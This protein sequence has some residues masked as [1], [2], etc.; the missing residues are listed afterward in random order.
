MA[1]L[2]RVISSSELL[3]QHFQNVWHFTS[4]DGVL[5]ETGVKDAVIPGMVTRLRNHQNANLIYST[6]SVQQLLPTLQPASVFSMAGAHG[7]LDGQM[8]HPSV[9]VLFSIRTGT[10]GRK[11]HGRWYMPGLHFDHVEN[12]VLRADIWALFQG[13][14]TFITNSYDGGTFASNLRM[15]VV[16]RENVAD[17]RPMTTV[18]VRQV[19]GIQRRRNIG[20]GA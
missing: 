13:D 12:G 14:A 1:Q 19:L 5:D 18:V 17:Y 4:E 10:G 6:M 15:V 20:V 3:G 8:Y 16:T 2:W 11:G 7:S 9:C